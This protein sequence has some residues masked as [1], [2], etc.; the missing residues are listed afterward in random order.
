MN[1][2]FLRQCEDTKTFVGEEA[3]SLDHLQYPMDTPILRKKEKKF[4]KE[5]P[6]P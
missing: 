2:L 3:T 1:K 4:S 6:V 5:F